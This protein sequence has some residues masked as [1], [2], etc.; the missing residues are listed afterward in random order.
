MDSSI[1]LERRRRQCQTR[2]SPIKFTDELFSNRI[3]LSMSNIPD[4]SGLE[5]F[6]CV[7]KVWNSG[8]F[9]HSY[10][11]E[12]DLRVTVR[13]LWWRFFVMARNSL[14]EDRKM[15]MGFV[16][17]SKRAWRSDIQGKKIESLMAP[18][19][20][21][22]PAPSKRGPHSGYAGWVRAWQGGGI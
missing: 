16:G 5:A 13:E 15:S 3:T 9:P 12:S 19:S 18:T 20:A 21:L 10:L 6:A 11:S 22:G 14:D 4:Q 8:D 1:V 17:E 7:I 2:V